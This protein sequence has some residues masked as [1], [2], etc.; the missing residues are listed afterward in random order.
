M[1]GSYGV[2]D[3]IFVVLVD[4]NVLG[5]D[6]TEFVPEQFRLLLICTVG[7]SVVLRECPS[8]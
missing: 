1:L 4:L 6:A 2:V 7:S 3:D 8:A 5:G